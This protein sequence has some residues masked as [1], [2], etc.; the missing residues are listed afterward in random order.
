MTSGVPTT[1]WR[2]QNGESE[3]TQSD[4]ADITT[5]SGLS[6]ITLSGNKLI[7]DAG[8]YI[9]KPATVWVENDAV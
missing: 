4:A 3:M 5:L 2:P 9:P 8:S 1:I 7:V 6:M